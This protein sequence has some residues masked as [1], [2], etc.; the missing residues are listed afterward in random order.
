MSVFM[1]VLTL[2]LR[3]MLQPICQEEVAYQD[4]FVGI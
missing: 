4:E 2:L 1:N 3:E